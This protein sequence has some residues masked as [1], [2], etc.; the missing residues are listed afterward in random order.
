[1]IELLLSCYLFAGTYTNQVCIDQQLVSNI[2]TEEDYNFKSK[3]YPY[4]DTLGYQTIGY[5]TLLP[6]SEEETTIL[7]TYRLSIVIKE[8]N[9]SLV[10]LDAP[11]EVWDILYEMAYQLGLRGLLDFSRMIVA[12]HNEDYSQ[13]SREMLDSEWFKQTPDRVKRLSDRM[14]LINKGL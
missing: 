8:V 1:M 13:A 3:G 7:L 11:D 14:K 6:L 2:K 9:E 10:G 12:L 5:G 4:N